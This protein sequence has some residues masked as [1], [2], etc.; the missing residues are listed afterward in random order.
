MVP[1]FVSTTDQVELCS[2]VTWRPC[3]ATTSCLTKRCAEETWICNLQCAFFSSVLSLWLLPLICP[4][5]CERPPH[6]RPFTPLYASS[7]LRSIQHYA[8]TTSH[9]RDNHPWLGETK[10]SWWKKRMMRTRIRPAW[11]WLVLRNA[12]ALDSI[13]EQFLGV[14]LNMVCFASRS[15][16][17]EMWW[18]KPKYGLVDDGMDDDSYHFIVYSIIKH[19]IVQVLFEWWFCLFSP[20]HF[21]CKFILF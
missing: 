19:M 17:F 2:V 18:T 15:F 10:S 14:M 3:R 5:H 12:K 7:H 16:S 13:N 6:P 20:F 21:K 8:S 9:L 11:L 1:S 4:S